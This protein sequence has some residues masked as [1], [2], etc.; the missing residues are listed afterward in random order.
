M[1]LLPKCLTAAALL[2]AALAQA[3]LAGGM[4]GGGMGGGGGGP[5][6][7]ITLTGV[8][9]T[10][11]GLID[12]TIGAGNIDMGTDGS[13]IYGA[14]YSGS[15]IGISG[16]LTINGDNGFKVDIF[17][18]PTATMANSAGATMGIVGVEIIV[19]RANKADVYGLGDPCLGLGTPALTHRIRKNAARNS[20]AVGMRINGTGG[21]PSGPGFY[22]TANPGGTA[23]TIDVVYQ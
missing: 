4:G 18:T 1:H 12:V 20:L 3:A 10:S 17:C 13:I 16:G 22:S 15:G 19:G 8:T 11:F 5:A 6:V 23:V 14:G 21:V 7:P 9:A 2:G